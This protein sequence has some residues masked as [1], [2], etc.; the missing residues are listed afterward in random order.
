MCLT[1]CSQRIILCVQSCII[2]F[3]PCSTEYIACLIH[4]SYLTVFGFFSV[5]CIL[6]FF[7]IERSKI[8]TILKTD[9][10]FNLQRV[11]NKTGFTVPLLQVCLCLQPT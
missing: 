6:P 10:V 7:G 3:V 1:D 2:K 4:F 11:A 8:D 9:E 5:S